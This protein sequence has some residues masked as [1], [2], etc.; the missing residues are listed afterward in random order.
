MPWS[1]TNPT[2]RLNAAPDPNACTLPPPRPPTPPIR[3][4]NTEADAHLAVGPLEKYACL[5]ESEHDGAVI[6][7]AYQ[8]DWV[9]VSGKVLA[10]EILGREERAHIV[11]LGRCALAAALVLAL[12][13]GRL[14]PTACRLARR[15]TVCS[16]SG[17]AGG[18]CTLAR[19]PGSLLLTTGLK[20]G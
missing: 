3:D 19:L 7:E 2:S 17:C 18:G 10:R 14:L 16:T 9:R 1:H 8:H 15:P 11:V 13:L 6:D 4:P 12:P 20:V 5:I